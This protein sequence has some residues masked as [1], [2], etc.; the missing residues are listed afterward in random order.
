MTVTLGLDLGEKRI[1]LA[2]SDGLGLA[3]R[4]VE[5]IDAADEA[6][7]IARV[8]EVAAGRGATR[9]VV[10]LPI[11]MNGKEGPAAQ[12]ARAF[13]EKLGAALPDVEVVLHD[14][15]MT[16]QQASRYLAARGHLSRAKQKQLID[17]LAAQAL[18][19][20]YLDA[21]GRGAGE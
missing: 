18:L 3:A 13:A 20:S 16:T 6:G 2:A 19:Q 17:A 5:A 1:G 8:G 4:A 21:Q 12:K 15:R 11:N 9:V 7:A 14:E 10:V